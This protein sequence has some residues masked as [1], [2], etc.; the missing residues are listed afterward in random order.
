MLFF[1]HILASLHFNENLHRETQK[2]KNGEKYYRITWPKFKA[3][4]EVI[5][6]V[7]CPPTYG[8]CNMSNDDVSHDPEWAKNNG[9]GYFMVNRAWNNFRTLDIVRTYLSK[10]WAIFKQPGVFV[11]AELFL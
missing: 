2:S 8:M 5:R 9:R 11:Q 3:G 4:E 1:R 7:A 10:V 6:E